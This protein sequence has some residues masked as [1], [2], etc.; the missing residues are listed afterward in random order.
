MRLASLDPV[1]PRR[2]MAKFIGEPQ[3]TDNLYI[4]AYVRCDGTGRNKYM[5]QVQVGTFTS[6]ITLL[7]SNCLDSVQVCLCDG[8]IFRCRR[9]LPNRTPS[10]PTFPEG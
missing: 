7:D 10:G 1:G 3:N 5:G 4:H 8:H 9:C 2:L 6:N